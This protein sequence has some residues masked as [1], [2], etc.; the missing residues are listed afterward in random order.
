VDTKVWDAIA[1]VIRDPDVLDITAKRTRLSIDA[2]RVEAATELAEVRTTLARVDQGR[3]RLLDLYVAGRIEREDFDR[4]EAPLARE[5]ER[6]RNEV[7][8]LEALVASGDA[9]AARHVAAVRYCE[10][11]SRGLDR[12]DVVGRQTLLRQLDVQVIVE[13]DRLVIRGHLPQVLPT[14]DLAIS[15]YL[16]IFRLGAVLG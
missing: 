8:R 15:M 10:L 3:A 14:G 9:E 6:L 1:S 12:L 2:R 5:Q 13:P 16:P 4:R 11:V 7:S